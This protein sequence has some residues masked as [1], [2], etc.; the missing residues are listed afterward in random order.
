MRAEQPSLV[1]FRMWRH[2]PAAHPS[3]AQPPHPIPSQPKRSPECAASRPDACARGATN[4]ST[5]VALSSKLPRSFW[6]NVPAS[7]GLHTQHTRRRKGGEQ[8][9]C[10]QSFFLLMPCGDAG[11]QERVVSAAAYPPALVCGDAP[12]HTHTHTHTRTRKHMPYRE[13]HPAPQ[14][15]QRRLQVL[16][17]EK[18]GVLKP[19][20]QNRLIA[21]RHHPH[22]CLRITMTSTSLSAVGHA[23]GVIMVTMVNTKQS[24][25][26][27]SHMTCA[28]HAYSL[29]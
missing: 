14:L 26:Q 11:M 17:V 23:G 21:C 25:P 6:N 7:L 8:C 27:L 10:T 12:P 20:A 13:A 18:G 3:A 4:A 15:I 9:A 16:V 19:G 5:R 28:A 22:G 1:G 2:L 29:G 24:L